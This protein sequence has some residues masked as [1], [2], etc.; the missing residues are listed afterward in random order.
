MRAFTYTTE[1][2]ICTCLCVY[3]YAFLSGSKLLTH[4]RQRPPEEA[5]CQI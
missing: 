4:P 2:S 5:S 1:S 3:V